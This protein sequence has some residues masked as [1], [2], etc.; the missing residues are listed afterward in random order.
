MKMDIKI[1]L[2]VGCLFSIMGLNAAHLV[3]GHISYEC[4][5]GN[6][7][8]VF[9]RV[10]RDCAGGGAAF[11]ADANIAVY[12][13]S[14][15][16]IQS[17]QVP[18]GATISVPLNS[19]GNPCLTPP[20]NLCTEYADYTT[21]FSL[22]PIV[23][24][25]T[26]VHQ[27]C[28]RNN[29]IDNVA[30]S[31]NFGNTYFV[32]IPSMDVTCNSSPAFNNPAPIVLCGN[33]PLNLTIEAIEKDGDSL[34][35]EFCDILE[36]GSS[37]GGGGGCFAVVPIPSCPPPY[38]PIGF[39]A[40][41]SPSQPLPGTPPISI[42]PQTG[43][44][45]GTPDQLGRFVVGI[46]VSEW[47]N[48]M[49]MSQIRLD[50]QFNI[51]NCVSNIVADMLTPAED[52]TLLCN[53]LNVQFQNESSNFNH[54]FWDFGVPGVS[55]DT[56]NLPNPVF[57]FPAPGNYTVLLVVNPGWQC[58]DSTTFDFLVQPDVN[59]SMS[60]SGV[61]CFEVQGIE[62]EAIGNF[63][64]NSTFDWNFGPGA[65]PNFSANLVPPA[66][67][68]SSPGW[69]TVSFTAYWPPTCSITF[70]DSVQISA[71]AATVDA[72]PNQTINRFESADLGAS[73]GFSF[74]WYS[75]IPSRYS[76]Q[77]QQNIRVWPQDDTT[78]YYV[79]VKDELGC[80]GIDSVQIFWQPDSIIPEDP[81]V[82]NVITPN[83]DGRNDF[84]DLSNVL[85]N[86]TARLLVLNR[87]GQEVL[88]R[89]NY[90]NDWDG[91][92]QGGDPLPDGTYYILLIGSQ[93][94]LYQGGVSIIRSN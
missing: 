58:S 38:T 67:T 40:P 18:K 50:Y 9:L 12:D 27:R 87:W 26:I 43:Q 37:G 66:V 92:D 49:Q 20:S 86:Q 63:P 53:G 19:T 15:N 41:Y 52:S 39:L 25:Y 8:Q 59:A 60:W 1:A 2:I 91:V 30:N 28:C 48:G 80:E 56:S 62:W 78:T 74:Y 70:V 36:G 45:S 65:S 76:G 46:C 3:G 23:G 47:R 81:Q 54:L 93:G 64:A 61:P 6:D 69:K 88:D 51:V 22:P 13:A 5:G 24:G 82:M 34:H 44:L 85:D 11:D 90:Q 4:I 21:T 79:I 10:Y 35:F 84:L 68:W 94:T 72:G 71:L 89:V 42:N 7:Y 29:S 17:V 83:A 77:F 16:L 32:T 31:G 57:S 73:S 33:E 55:T 75:D 14:N